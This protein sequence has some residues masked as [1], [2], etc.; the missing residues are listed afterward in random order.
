MLG[1]AQVSGLQALLD[2]FNAALHRPAQL[3]EPPVDRLRG[4]PGRGGL[5]QEP[6]DACGRFLRPGEEERR[7]N[8]PEGEDRERQPDEDG[9][10][11]HQRQDSP[12]RDK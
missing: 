4:F 10:G 5:G 7:R 3:V 8:G 6:V 2:S 1:Q 9:F 11:G 12:E